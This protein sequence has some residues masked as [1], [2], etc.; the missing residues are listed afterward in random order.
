VTK[1]LLGN[2]WKLITFIVVTGISWDGNRVPN[3][4]LKVVFLLEE[5]DQ[6]FVALDSNLVL[7]EVKLEELLHLVVIRL[8]GLFQDVVHLLGGLSISSEVEEVL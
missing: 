4:G 8:V 7:Q 1:Q 5:R 3:E 6:L 2:I